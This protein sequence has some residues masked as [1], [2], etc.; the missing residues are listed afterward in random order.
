MKRFTKSE[1][2]KEY[3]LWTYGNIKWSPDLQNDGGVAMVRKGEVDDA[4]R[5]EV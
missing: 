1:R 4:K 5:R 2:E 3:K